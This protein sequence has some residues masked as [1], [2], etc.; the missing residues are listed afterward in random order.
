MHDLS[1]QNTDREKQ[2]RKEKKK[3]EETT[4]LCVSTHR[5]K[6]RPKILRE[7]HYYLSGLNDFIAILI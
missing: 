4:F 5:L 6:H 1:K 7:F 2:H 3:K